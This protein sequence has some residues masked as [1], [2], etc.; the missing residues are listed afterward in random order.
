MDIRGNANGTGEMRMKNIGKRALKKL[1][2]RRGESLVEVLVTLLICVLALGM[3]STAIIT[4]S[5]VTK[6]S[7][8]KVNDYYT[9]MNDI[10]KMAGTGK[11]GKI[12]ISESGS[13]F[14][15]TYDVE[16]FV[17]DTYGNKPVIAYRKK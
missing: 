2:S 7:D 11:E 15:E 6:N 16:Y 13:S 4:S 3:L 12:T 17:N 5:A 14:S 1:H 9:A 10:A 8:K